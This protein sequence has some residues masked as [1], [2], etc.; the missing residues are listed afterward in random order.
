MAMPGIGV[1][2][3]MKPH[4]PTMMKTMPKIVANVRVFIKP[5]PFAFSCDAYWGA[6]LPELRVRNQRLHSCPSGI[7]DGTGRTFPG[8]GHSKKPAMPRLRLRAAGTSG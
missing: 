1:R 4:M 2:P 5:L 7:D 3:G 6:V 8:L